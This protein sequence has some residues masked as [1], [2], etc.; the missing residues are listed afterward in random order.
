MVSTQC[1]VEYI[2][3]SELIK[4]LD[5]A[6]WLTVLAVPIRLQPEV[7]EFDIQTVQL[8]LDSLLHH[9]VY[10]TKIGTLDAL[11]VHTCVWS[12]CMCV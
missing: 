12:V 3:Y 10:S 9:I 1:N 4:G 8:G 7:H 11:C 5:A 2:D 6:S